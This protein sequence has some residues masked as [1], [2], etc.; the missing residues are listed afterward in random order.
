MSNPPRLIHLP[1]PNE[2]RSCARWACLQRIPG[3][4]PDPAVLSY[5]V[6]RIVQAVATTAIEAAEVTGTIQTPDRYIDAFLQQYWEG[7]STLPGP[8]YPKPLLAAAAERGGVCVETL[9]EQILPRLQY[10]ERL[11]AHNQSF[12]WKISDGIGGEL[13]IPGVIA[14]LGEDKLTGVLRIYDWRIEDDPIFHAKA[15]L[16]YQQIG[17]AMGWLKSHYPERETAHVEVFLLTD[18]AWE[19][20]RSHYELCLIEELLRYQ[21]AQEAAQD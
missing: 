5:H 4:G 12:A 2:V 19:T 7:L 9:V 17:V 20:R 14:R 15:A 13:V 11:L 6:E 3:T 1:T 10:R 16:R 21:A 8:G 18:V